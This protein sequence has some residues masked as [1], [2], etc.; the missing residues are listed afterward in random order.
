MIFSR[1][2]VRSSFGSD[3]TFT[4]LNIVHTSTFCHHYV[5]TCVHISSRKCVRSSFGSDLTFTALNIVHTCTFCHHYV[6]TFH[7]LTHTAVPILSSDFKYLCQGILSA[8]PHPRG[9]LMS[10][11]YL[12]PLSGRII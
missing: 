6:H 8:Q 11:G 10:P 12:L 5:H 1:K 2:C 3:L 4:A 7:R 9:E